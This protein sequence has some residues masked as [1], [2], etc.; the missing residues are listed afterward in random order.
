MST[1]RDTARG[2][3]SATTSTL[4]ASGFTPS[5]SSDVSSWRSRSGF[6]PVASAQAAQKASWASSP[7]RARTM[8]DAAS[9]LSGP[10]R[11]ERVAGSWPISAMSAG[12]VPGSVLRSVAPTT[13]GMSSSRRAR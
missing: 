8:A 4:A 13:T 2:P 9:A 3:I 7:S 1:V 6:P 12:S 10:G 5:A 11:T